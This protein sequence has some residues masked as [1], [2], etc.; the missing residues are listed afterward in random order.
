MRI[1]ARLARMDGK[2][3][4]RYAGL[5]VIERTGPRWVGEIRVA[6][7]LLTWP[8]Y[9]R[10]S[11]RIAVDAMSDL[12]HERLPTAT[13]DL[14]HAVMTAA[15]WH[16]F[17]V[18]T[19]RAARMRAYYSD[20][21]TPRRIIESFESLLSI[22]NSETK[23]RAASLRSVR[24][25]IELARE[26]GRWPLPNLW[27]GVSVEDQAR[28]DR[29]RDLLETPAAIRWVCFE[30]LLDRVQLDAVPVGDSY[31]DALGGN[32][33]AVDGRGR[34]V[35]VD[36]PGWRPLDWVVAAGEIGVGARPMQPHWLRDL[37]NKCTAGRIPFFFRQWGE[38]AP[39]SAGRSRQMTRLGKRAAGRLLDGRTWD[40]IPA[41]A[42]P[43]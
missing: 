43:C 35:A 11:R 38:W 33:Y 19:K 23:R 42:Q 6:E 41:A 1:A 16:H 24:Q 37:R 28:I 7:D 34:A 17:L 32:H 39:A 26:I 15:R 31:F 12:F 22:A 4:A 21:H 36:G 3:G 20:P 18:L 29:V 14:L 40:E 8:L 5:T 30:P 2:T 27:L 10:R 13:V 25:G 9:Q